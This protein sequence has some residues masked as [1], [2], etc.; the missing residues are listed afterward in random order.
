M[1]LTVEEFAKGLAP[2]L[3]QEGFTKQRLNWRKD[4]GATI[5]VLNVQ[6]SA[7]GDR[8]YYVNVG[9]Y[10]KALGRGVGATAQPLPCPAT[11]RC[12][13]SA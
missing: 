13:V 10:L 6:V 1:S 12:V 4:L 7:W 5:A 3:K 11:S 8:S 2:L 9:I